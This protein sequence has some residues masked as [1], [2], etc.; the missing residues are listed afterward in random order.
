MPEA[1]PE[2]VEDE[3]P[4]QAAGT[5]GPPEAEPREEAAEQEQAESPA[6]PIVR[7]LERAIGCPVVV[8]YGRGTMHQVDADP[9]YRL[10][11]AMGTPE[12]LA[13]VIHSPGG[14][15]DAAH[16]L[17]EMLHQFTEH[18]DVFVPAD[19]AYS[20]ATLLA[21]SA[22]SL[23]MGP[24]SELSPIDPQVAVDPRLLIPTLDPQSPILRDDIIHVPAHVIRDFLE[25]SG[26]TPPRGGRVSNVDTDRLKQLLSPLLNPWILGWYE[27]ADKVSRYY[28][29]LALETYLLRGEDDA[30]GQAD[31]IVTTLMDDYASHEAGILRSPARKMGIP[32]KDCPSD[33]WDKLEELMGIYSLLP[34]NVVRLLETANG[35]ELRTRARRTC[36]ACGEASEANADFKFCPSCGN[37]FERH[38]GS[39]QGV[40]EADWA[41]CARCGAR[42]VGDNRHDAASLTTKAN[43]SVA[44]YTGS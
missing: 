28:A 37:A 2:A 16:L 22:D 8:Y 44:A 14:D 40:V 33:A 38:C 43:G 7:D 12:R 41:F 15:P 27:R 29:K 13:L 35:Y 6:A 34:R 30:Q 19:G 21:L 42:V 20:A 36:A 23:W 4:V 1:D 39:C 31:R 3:S 9:L 10:L 5:E 17:S 11:A 25:L 18:L 32:V 24:S 26:V